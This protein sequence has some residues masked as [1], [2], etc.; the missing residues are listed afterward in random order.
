[1]TKDEIVDLPVEAATFC[2][3]DVETTG[4]SAANGGIIEIALVKVDNLKITENLSTQFTGTRYL[5]NKLGAEISI[6]KLPEGTAA[7]D[8]LNAELTNKN[9]GLNSTRYSNNI[10]TGKDLIQ[11]YEYSCGSI[12]FLMIIKVSKYTYENY[13]D[14][15]NNIINSFKVN[16]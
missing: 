16:C 9:D 14:H 11:Y 5:N 10:E 3:V 6:I 8:F 15:Y 7:E 12:K 1:M 4:L 2:I 13:K